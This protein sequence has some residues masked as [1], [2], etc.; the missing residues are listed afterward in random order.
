MTSILNLRYHHYQHLDEKLNP[1]KRYRDIMTIIISSSKSSW[2]K[3][4]AVAYFAVLGGLWNP[5]HMLAYFSQLIC[6]CRRFN[7]PF[8]TSIVFISPSLIEPFIVSGEKSAFSYI[9]GNGSS[10]VM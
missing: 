8:N 4:I 6:Y 3:L 10:R 5:F 9:C 2:S 7:R 1:N